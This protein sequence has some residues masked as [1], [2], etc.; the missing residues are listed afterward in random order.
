MPNGAS[1]RERVFAQP[2]TAPRTVL[3]TPRFAIGSRTEVDTTLTMRPKPAARMPGA[4]DCTSTW[5]ARRWRRNAVSNS[6][7][8]AVC[9][10]PPLGPAVLLTR[11]CTGL[12]LPTSACTFDC[13]VAT[14]SM[15][16]ASQPCCWPLPRGRAAATSPSTA[17]RRASTVTSAPS[18]ASSCAAARPMPSEA[19]HTSACLPERSRSISDLHS[20]VPA[21]G[22][23]ASGT[24]AA[25]AFHRLRPAA[26]AP[27]RG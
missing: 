13:R 24:S 5:P 26:A 9:A 15:S 21:R 3:D 20:A 1:S 7:I 12:P 22:R 6:S 4:T 17:S 8:A 27:R 18:S 10:G 16:A 14:S 11:M 25:P 2:A 23:Q 19:P